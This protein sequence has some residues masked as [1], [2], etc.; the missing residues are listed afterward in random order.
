VADFPFAR[1]TVPL[2]RVADVPLAKVGADPLVSLVA[3]LL[4]GVANVPFSYCRAATV[5]L[6]RLAAVL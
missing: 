4:A 3:V 6:A 2:A 5:S 1:V